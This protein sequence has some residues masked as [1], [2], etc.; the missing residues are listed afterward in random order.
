MLTM[1]GSTP[2]DYAVIS[3]S[4]QSHNQEWVKVLVIKFPKEQFNIQQAMNEMK[5]AK[6]ITDTD[7]YT[8]KTY[9]LDGIMTAKE[10]DC[11]V[12]VWLFICNREMTEN[13]D[14]KITS[15]EEQI[16]HLEQDSMESQ[17]TVTDLELEN[18][19]GQQYTTELE[20]ELLEGGIGIE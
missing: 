6:I 3:E 20:L 9:Y 18:I 7:E 14:V 2:L 19:Q 17:Q 13:P 8:I 10:D 16:I 11:F 15:L 1:N 5:D 12:S 4:L